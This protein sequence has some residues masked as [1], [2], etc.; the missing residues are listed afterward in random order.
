MS[1]AAWLYDMELI[2]RTCHIKARLQVS[3]ACRCFM[4]DAKLWWM[5]LDERDMPSRTWAH[6]RTLVI[7]QFGLVLDDG[8]NGPPRDPEIYR[9]MIYIRYH[10]GSHVYDLSRLFTA[11]D[12][13]APQRSGYRGHFGPAG[14]AVPQRSRAFLQLPA[15]RLV[16]N[17][18]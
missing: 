16:K 12:S 5:T 17:Q 6:F 7:A 8:T 13:P 9:D 11:S 14:D 1:I 10:G 4:G 3:L 15:P 18:R 2:L